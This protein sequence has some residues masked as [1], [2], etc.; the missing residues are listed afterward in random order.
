MAVRSIKGMIGGTFNHWRLTKFIPSIIIAAVVLIFISAMLVIFSGSEPNYTPLT[1]K[2][3]SCH[4][5]T[6]YPVDTDNNSVSA[7]YKRPHNNAIMCE[8]CHGPDL[9]NI[10][11]IQPNGTYGQRSASAGCPDCHL[12]KIQNFTSASRYP[13]AETLLKPK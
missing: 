4:N 10:S 6:G 9:H 13:G 8:L 12:T 2:C 3:I 5:D 11:F 7:P 1:N